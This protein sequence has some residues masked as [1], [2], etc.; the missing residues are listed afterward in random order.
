MRESKI[1]TRGMT[2]SALLSAVV[3]FAAA[4]LVHYFVIDR[5]LAAQGSLSWSIAAE[6]NV[7]LRNL[8]T[9]ALFASVLTIVSIY[10]LSRRGFRPFTGFFLGFSLFFF[11]FVV[12]SIFL[13]LT[14]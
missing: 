13:L 9:Y 12:L 7:I 1:T 2:V 10:G 3:G 8:A 11:G 6:R 5:L 14:V 4:A